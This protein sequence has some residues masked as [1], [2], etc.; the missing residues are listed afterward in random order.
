MIF[1]VFLMKVGVGVHQV[2]IHI[3]PISCSPLISR[4]VGQDGKGSSD[5]VR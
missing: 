1:I 3:I 4:V 5:P 2:I